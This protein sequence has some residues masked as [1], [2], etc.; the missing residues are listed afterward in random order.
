MDLSFRDSAKFS[1][2]GF[3]VRRLKWF[4]GKTF[5]IL[6][7]DLWKG[8]F[9]NTFLLFEFYCHEKLGDLNEPK[10]FLY[11]RETKKC[12][13]EKSQSNKILR[14][15]KMKLELNCHLYPMSPLYILC[16]LNC[17]LYPMSPLYI[18]CQSRNISSKAWLYT[19]DIFQEKYLP[20]YGY[21]WIKEYNSPVHFHVNFRRWR[22]KDPFGTCNC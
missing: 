9:K 2:V 20:R 18:L 21:S 22:H 10:R 5:P 14:T 7:F 6:T 19:E 11:L 12:E 15:E 1:P 16:H 3:F 8:L 17:H 13:L 4:S